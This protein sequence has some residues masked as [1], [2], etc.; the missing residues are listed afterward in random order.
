MD[1]D[2]ISIGVIGAS[3][4]Y[5]WARRA[6]MPALAALP[7]YQLMAV[8]T[9][10]DESAKQSKELYGAQKAYS[11][12]REIISDPEIDVIDICV[13]APSHYSIALEAL[14]SGKHVL[15]EWPLAAS[16]IQAQELASVARKQNS[17]TGV[18][19]Q[20]RYAPGFMYVRELLRDGYVGDVLSTNM[21]MFL[22][23]QMRS[24]TESSV[25]SA[26]KSNGAHVLSIHTGHALDVF[27]WCI[28]S[29]FGSVQSIVG[30]QS[31]TATLTDTQRVIDVTSPDNVL[32]QGRLENNALASVHIA[33]IPSHGSAF[34]ME[35]YGTE[36]TLIAQSSQMV[37]MI[38]PIITGARAD[39][40]KLEVLNPPEHLNLVPEST[41]AGVAANV[42]QMF[43]RFADCLKNGQEFSPSF[44]EAAS[45]QSLLD[46]IDNDALA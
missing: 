27:L 37:E 43:R 46:T 6:H 39:E 1:S 12:Y 5:G 20:S 14:K 2:K 19:L 10:N 35:I 45:R 32:L 33:S 26:E 38:D 34:R 17:Q 23:G 29:E 7:E 4:H 9:T 40:G 16:S 18:I 31:L 42:A 41:P 13:R 28:G 21:T 36:G 44:E 30:V 15:C 24:R 25:W 11:D 22:P 3:A 8:C